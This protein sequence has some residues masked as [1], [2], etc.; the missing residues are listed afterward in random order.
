M[1]RLR[2]D[3]SEHIY[4]YPNV[5]AGVYNN[6]AVR[7]LP[8][9]MAAGKLYRNTFI[10]D[11]P[12]HFQGIHLRTHDFLLAISDKQLK[13]LP[14]VQGEDTPAATALAADVAAWVPATLTNSWANVA[15]HGV[16]RYKKIG[17]KVEGQFALEAGTAQTMFTLATPYR[18]AVTRVIPVT[19]VTGGAASAGVVKV[20]TDG[21][22]VLD[23]PTGVSGS[24][25]VYGNLDFSRI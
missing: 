6:N 15:G 18:P 14:L 9:G 12:I 22:V 7:A 21:T 5:V 17:E 11:S 23:L 16:A 10:L 24:H 20:N 13:K 19:V 4:R 2:L 1:A 8:S 3:A 25:T